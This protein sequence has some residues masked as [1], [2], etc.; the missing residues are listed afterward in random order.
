VH[1]PSL[2]AL[3][4]AISMVTLCYGDENANTESKAEEEKPAIE[5][6]G[7]VTVDYGS[8]MSDFKNPSFGI[9]EVDLGANVN[10]SDEVIAS[11]LVMAEER[12]DSL[13]IDQAMVS[14]KPKSAPLELLFGQQTMSHGLL[15]TRMISDP[16]ILE[17][18]ETMELIKPSIVISGT[19]NRFTGGLGLTL[20]SRDNGPDLDPDG[21]YSAVVNLDAA[22]PN[23]SL[24]R[25]SSLANEEYVDVDLAGTINYWKLAFDFESI[26]NVKSSDDSARP[27]GFYASMLYDVVD[28]VSVALRVDG[29]AASDA[30][31]KDMEMR[32]AGGV[33]VKIKDGIFC[34]L[35]LSRLVNVEGDAYDE[36]AFEIGLEQTIQLPG[37]QRKTLTRE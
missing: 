17:N 25:L 28:P 20:F 26:V 29:Q 21:L 33:T 32:Y 12:L 14:Y 5:L 9:G 22:L 31:F 27:S 23:E 34:A 16:L 4:A 7:Y 3:F 1:V 30:V 18:I 36:I 13:W 2:C 37:F 11:I 10:I 8:D 6:G 35:E 15:T 24:L 19:M